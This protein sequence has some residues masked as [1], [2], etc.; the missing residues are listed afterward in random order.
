MKT[1]RLIVALGL[2]LLVAGAAFAGSAGAVPS[3]S[4]VDGGFVRLEDFEKVSLTAQEA[5]NGFLALHQ[6]EWAG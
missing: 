2:L 6:L 1:R 3:E 4:L 5:A